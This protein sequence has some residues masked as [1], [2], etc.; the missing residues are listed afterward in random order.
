MIITNTFFKLPR[1]K[2]YTWKSN[3][4]THIRNQIDFILIGDRYRNCVKS[5]K[6]YPGANARQRRKKSISDHNP[7]VASVQLKLKKTRQRR[8]KSI[9]NVFNLKEPQVLQ[10]IKEK[11]NNNISNIA[12]NSDQTADVNEK[13]SYMQNALIS[14]GEET[15]STRTEAKQIWMTDEILILM[16]ERRKNK[17]NF[18]KYKELKSKIKLAK[19]EW[20]RKNCEEIEEYE[21]KYDSFNM[22]K[23][24]KEMAGMKRYR[25]LNVLEDC[26]KLITDIEQ[27]LEEWTRY[28]KNLFEDN[29]PELELHQIEDSGPEILESEVVY[30][31]QQTK[32]GR[33]NG[34][35]GIPVEMLK[36]IDD[37]SIGVIVDLFNTIYET[38]IIPKQWLQSIFVTLPEKPNAKRCSEYRTIALMSHTLKVLLRVIHNRIFRKLDAEI[39]DN[40]VGFR[41]GMGT[42]EALFG[43]NMLMQR[44]LDVNQNI[45]MCFIDFEKAFDR[46]Q[47]QKLIEILK[48]KNIDGRDIRLIANLYWSQKAK[49]KIEDQTSDE[50]EIKRGVRQG[51]VLSP[52]LFNVYSEAIFQETLTLLM[53]TGGEK[54]ITINGEK[55]NNFRYADDTVLITDNVRDLQTL[56]QRLSDAFNQYG[57]NMNLKK[58]KY[59]IVT[60]KNNIDEVSL[61][62]DNTLI[63]KVQ[64]YKY[65]GTWLNETADHEQEIKSRIEIARASFIKLKKFLCSRDI[66]LQVRTRMLRCYVFSTLLYGAEAWT[67]KN[68][69]INRLE[70]FER[71]CYRQ[72]LRISCVDTNEEVLRR[73]KKQEEIVR[74]LK[75]KKLEYFAHVIRGTKYKLLQNIMEGKIKG[76]RSR[77][78]RRTS[79]FKNLEDWFGMSSIELFRAAVDKDK[80]AMMIAN[81]Q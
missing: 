38:G 23:K 57:L 34:P 72:M 15:L 75:K 47:H 25:Q 45:Y 66:N 35:D 58:T 55:V 3:K 56:L 17:S 80:I 71:W 1:R 70:A 42:R 20:I 6:T 29:R 76:T 13:W 4:A 22:H 63:E 40:Q 61:K 79:W 26:G 43:V 39:S 49:I 44:C 65:L 78:R 10:T 81:L 41:K 68:S 9:V 12:H 19:E 50:M 2:L 28:I 46:V 31:I 62:I 77:G 11:I 27:Q 51:C 37:N 54:G 8:K 69:E 7:L 60:K 67:L 59:M 30:A 74:T 36:L 64:H 14:A 53:I 33:A 21:R 24:I 18:H 32:E 52:L 16:E 48:Q 5:V 73:M